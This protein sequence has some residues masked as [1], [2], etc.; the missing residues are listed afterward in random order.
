MLIYAWAAFVQS[1]TSR[2]SSDVD[3]GMSRQ[4]N[5]CNSISAFPLWLG[6]AFS[7]CSGFL[8]CIL[9]MQFKFCIW[10]AGLL[11][12][13]TKPLE[14]WTVFSGF[15]YEIIV[16][17]YEGKL[18]LVVHWIKIEKRKLGINA[19]HSVR[20]LTNMNSTLWKTTLSFNWRSYNPINDRSV[21][22]VF[23]KS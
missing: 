9:W 23:L 15:R 4:P 18:C 13:K 11:A 6:H 16:I 5:W 17:N 8:T 7:M 19:L 20:K 10:Q 21:G 22:K 2:R 3:K 1:R 14:F 12:A